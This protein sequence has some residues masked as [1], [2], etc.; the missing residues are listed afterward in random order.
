MRFMDIPF[1]ELTRAKCDA[2][3]ARAKAAYR[4]YANAIRAMKRLL[5]AKAD[6]GD[7]GDGQ[8]PTEAAEEGGDD[9]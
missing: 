3:E 7:M 5:E 8:K 6:L 9:G 2:E 1:S 4:A